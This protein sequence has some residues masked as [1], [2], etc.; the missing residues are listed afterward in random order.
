MMTLAESVAWRPEIVGWSE[1]ILP[2]YRK[3]AERLPAKALVAEVGVFRGRSICFL[4]EEF[5][6]LGKDGSQ[7]WGFDPGEAIFGPGSPQTHPNLGHAYPGFEGPSRP[8]LVANL[9]RTS[10]FRGGVVVRAVAVRSTMGAQ[11][12]FDHTLD[13]VFLDGDHTAEGVREDILAWAPKL[14]AGG[15]LAGHDYGHYAWSGVKDVVDGLRYRG[16]AP[17]DGVSVEG[18]VWWLAPSSGFVE[19][20]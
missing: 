2:F 4:A 15:V 18:S 8:A 19:V 7:I 17:P 5:H 14:R 16:L 12:F 6:R 20:F 11:L 9:E 13:M 10:E 1:D 3:M